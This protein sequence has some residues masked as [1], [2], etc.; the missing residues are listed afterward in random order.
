MDSFR[1]GVLRTIEPQEK[2]C[3]GAMEMQESGTLFNLHDIMSFSSSAHTVIAFRTATFGAIAYADTT[4]VQ[5]CALPIEMG[6]RRT[7]PGV[8]HQL[9]LLHCSR[10]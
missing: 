7:F 6:P 9:F 8:S 2:V 5:L 10:L 3:V 1:I 4:C